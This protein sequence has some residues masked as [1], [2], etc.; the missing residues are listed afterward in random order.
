MIGNFVINFGVDQFSG[1]LTGAASADATP[2][3]FD[4]LLDY[5]I[6]GGTGR[7]A[8]ATG[9]FVGSGTADPRVRPSIVSLSFAAVP[10]A[11]TWAMMLLGFGGIGLVLRRRRSFASA[12]PGLSAGPI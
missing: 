5:T 10:E 8:G 11:S 12:S 4:L 9:T 6:T 3:L 7:F 1:T 2:G